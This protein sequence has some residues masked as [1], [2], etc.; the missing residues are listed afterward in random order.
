M[1]RENKTGREAKGIPYYRDGKL[2]NCL[3]LSFYFKDVEI[4]TG[5]V[6]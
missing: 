4:R 3:I 1:G 2:S 5:K 6:K